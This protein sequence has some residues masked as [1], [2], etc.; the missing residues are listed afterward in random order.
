MSAKKKKTWKSIPVRKEDL[1]WTPLEDIIKE[2]M[3]SPV[4][5][6]EYKQAMS[7]IRLAKELYDVRKAK[8]MTQ[9]AVADKALM[10]QSVIA[11]LE[12]GE[13]SASIATLS[14]VASA[15]GK[16]IALVDAK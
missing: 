12:S 9:K 15:L 4:F 3:K 6:R 14:K 1:V 13:H 11:R 16:Q 7:R 8:H 10:P 5:R 2:S